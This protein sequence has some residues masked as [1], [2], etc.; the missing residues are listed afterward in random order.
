MLAYLFPGKVAILTQNNVHFRL[1]IG[2]KHWH[3]SIHWRSSIHWHGGV[4]S[5]WISSVPVIGE[6]KRAHSVAV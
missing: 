5:P 3:S 2:Q 4:R 1:T 6:R